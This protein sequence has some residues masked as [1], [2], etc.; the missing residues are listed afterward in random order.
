MDYGCAVKW[1]VQTDAL[2]EP[3]CDQLFRVPAGWSP[4]RQLHF[5]KQ[6]LWKQELALVG[7]IKSHRLSGSHEVTR[8]PLRRCVILHRQRER[9]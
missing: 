4:T 6:H 2:F 5:G 1:R 8:E 3:H 9:S 7:S